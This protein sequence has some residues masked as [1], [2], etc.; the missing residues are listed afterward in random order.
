MP[1]LCVQIFPEIN[2][3]SCF[4]SGES[5][6][7][8]SPP[9]GANQS[10]YLPVRNPAIAP[11]HLFGQIHLGFHRF[12]APPRGTYRE[13][14]QWIGGA[15]VSHH[16][17]PAFF[18]QLHTRTIECREHLVVRIQHTPTT[19]VWDSS[20]QWDLRIPSFL[21]KQPQSSQDVGRVG[22]NWKTPARRFSTIRY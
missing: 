4:I 5:S 18:S 20:S 17:F 15:F 11:K 16:P 13:G 22:K 6:A 19:T 9:T 21:G 3:K 7:Q 1:S 10:Q 14:N 12:I 8:G 2:R